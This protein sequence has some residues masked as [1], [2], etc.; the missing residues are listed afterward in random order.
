MIA[1]L[2]GEV[3]DGKPFLPE[4]FKQIDGE[5]GT[6]NNIIIGPKIQ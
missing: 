1:V 3:Q 5:K 2:L 6:E 4:P